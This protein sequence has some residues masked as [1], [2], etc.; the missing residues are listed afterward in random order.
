MQINSILKESRV[1]GPGNRAVIWVQGCRLHCEDCFNVSAQ[2]YE[3]G[4][5]LTPEQIFERIDCNVVE[6]ITISGGEPFD[7]GLELKKL[8]KLAKKSNLNTLV[9][10]G[11]LYEKLIHKNHDILMLCDYLIDG[12]FMKDVPSRCRWAGSGNQRFLQ[13][14]NGKQINNLT[15]REEYSQ[16]AEIIIEENGNITITGFI[17]A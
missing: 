13:L 16:N 14:K 10:T 6:G 4:I 3:G 15:V 12:P 9:Y 7:Q 1:N 8:L 5:S 17:E 11:Y 2:S